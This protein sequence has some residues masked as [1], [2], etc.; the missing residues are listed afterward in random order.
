MTI[1]QRLTER[2][3]E[4]QIDA[5][6]NL[7][8][9]LAADHPRALIQMATGAGKTYTACVFSHRLLDH[10]KFRRVLFLA[11]RANLGPVHCILVDQI[12]D[13]VWR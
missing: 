5:V 13:I 7:E 12:S 8:T 6:T 9:S 3:R 2:L 1:R 4:C 10:A 11:D